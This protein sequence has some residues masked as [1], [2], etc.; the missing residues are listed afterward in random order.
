MSTQTTT[1]S[2]TGM[3]CS[4]CVGAVRKNLEALAGVTVHDV[5][6]GS[7]VIESNPDVVTMSQL[8][9]AVEE[10]GFALDPVSDWSHEGDRG[11]RS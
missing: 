7:A 5:T 4:H 3:S 1:L 11:P 9:A 10:A 2:I 8:T 6:V